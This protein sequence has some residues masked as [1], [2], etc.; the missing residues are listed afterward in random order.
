ML[1]RRT[2][3]GLIVSAVSFQEWLPCR[4]ASLAEDAFTQLA[5]RIL[6]P[7]VKRE[8]LVNEN[9][10]ALDASVLDVTPLDQFGVMG[11]EDHETNLEEWRLV[12]DGDVENPLTL[13]YSQFKAFP[14][15]EKKALMICRGIFANNGKWKGVS[16]R[17]LLEMARPRS[18]ATYVVVKGPPGSYEKV[19][20][21][22][23]EEALSGRLLFAYEVNGEVLPRRNGFPVRLVA[24]GFYGD[25]WTKYV[26][27]ISVT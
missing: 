9:P 13:D 11:L 24:E 12:V 8:D 7:G 20:K 16:A 4:F 26:Y 10:A 6:A 15:A 14:S 23:L 21:F 5:K 17:D 2:F 27:K 3:L 25:Q 19:E 22:S 1:T 18:D